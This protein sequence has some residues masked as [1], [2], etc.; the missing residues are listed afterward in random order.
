MDKK[1]I[2]VT[3]RWSVHVHR[4]PL[5]H[6]IRASGQNWNALF[7]FQSLLNMHRMSQRS[8]W[9]QFF[10]PGVQKNDPQR[11][12]SEP[13]LPCWTRRVIT[14]AFVYPKRLSR[15]H[16][17]RCHL[18]GFFRADVTGGQFREERRQP[19]LS[20]S[21]CLRVQPSQAF[22][23]QMILKIWEFREKQWFIPLNIL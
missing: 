19:V 5:K 11:E 10:P 13:C 17:S 3:W 14:W 20:F 18:I 16:F 2:S 8:P 21:S 23:Q 6:W 9:G 1:K 4:W 12:F 7:S 22:L 15:S